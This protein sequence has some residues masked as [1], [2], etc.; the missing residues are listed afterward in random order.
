MNGTLADAFS[1]HVRTKIYPELT[2]RSITMAYARTPKEHHPMPLVSRIGFM[3]GV[4]MIY[5]LTRTDN[6]L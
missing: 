5:T 1:V 4:T 3:L 6:E 2:V